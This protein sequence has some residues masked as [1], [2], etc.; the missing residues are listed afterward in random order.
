MQSKFFVG[1]NEFARRASDPG[2][3]QSLVDQAAALNT[4]PLDNR[5]CY[6]VLVGELAGFENALRKLKELDEKIAGSEHVQNEKVLR[7][8]DSLERLYTDY[9]AGMLNGP[10]VGEK[11]RADLRTTLGWFADLALAPRGGPNP[12]ARQALISSA[13]AVFVVFIVVLAIGCLVGFAGLIGLFT[14]IGLYLA[15]NLS[16]GVVTGGGQGGIYAETFALWMVVFLVFSSAPLVIEVEGAEMLITGIGILASLVVLIWPVV[17]GGIPWR[18][19]R[20][21]IGLVAGRQPLLEPLLGPAGYA[22]SMPLLAV[23]VVMTLILIS[24]QGALGSVLSTAVQVDDF[25]PS[26]FPAHPIIEMLAGP[27]WWVKLQVLFLGSIVAP[28]VEE[29]MFRGVLY[30]HMRESTSRWPFFLS[31]AA[32]AL[33][34]S[35]VFAVIHPQGLVAVPALMALAMGF[36]IMRE[37]RGS[38][39]SCMLAH[40]LNNALVM[41]LATFVFNI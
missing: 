3:G 33:V 14:L 21:D 31:F 13:Q 15:G 38:L 18:Q 5:L 30:R 37:W 11:D 35:F 10:S 28:I 40:G 17:R 12:E 39:I 36:T 20:K 6:A 29:T 1:Y 2:S 16:R 24:L 26:G 27:G 25:G 9:A 34:V 19:V 23:G 41:S 32:S 8:Q 22:M 4:G 7:A